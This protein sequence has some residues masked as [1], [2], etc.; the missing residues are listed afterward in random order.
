MIITAFMPLIEAII[1]YF[2]R[3]LRRFIDRS[4]SCKKDTYNTKTKSIQGYMNIHSG[5]IYKMHMKYAN[6]M[7]IIFITMTFGYGIPIL[8]PIAAVAIAILYLV[9]KTMLYYSYQ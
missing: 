5:P 8:F 6:L 9:E 3:A 2:I 7:N 4:M 1:S